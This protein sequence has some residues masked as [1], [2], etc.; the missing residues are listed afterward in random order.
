M[1]GA[2]HDGANAPNECFT[3]ALRGIMLRSLLSP[4]NDV[5]TESLG[6]LSLVLLG[7]RRPIIGDKTFHKISQSS[8]SSSSSPSPPSA[9]FLHLSTGRRERPTQL[10]R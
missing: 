10:P 5:I 1:A 6:G 3:A 4:G 2:G 9:E 7:R 8:T